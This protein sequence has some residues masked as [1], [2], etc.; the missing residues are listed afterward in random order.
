[1]TDI[2]TGGSPV[3]ETFTS[4]DAR[5]SL[6]RPAYA[7]NIDLW[8]FQD[9]VDHVQR[10][11]NL[12][13]RSLEKQ[14]SMSVVMEA[15]RDIPS[16]NEWS[17]L[18]RRA[19]IT[20]VASQSTGSISYDHTGGANERQVTLVGA[21]F[22]TDVRYYKISIEGLPYKVEEFISNTVLTLSVDSSPQADIAAG[23]V[24]ELYRSIYPMPPDFRR[25]DTLLELNDLGH[26][27]RY[28]QPRELIA[29]ESEFV[30]AFDRP[31][32]FTIRNSD[33]EYGVLVL[34]FGPPPSVS[35]TYDMVYRASPRTIRTFGQDAEYSTGTIS[36]S[37][38]DITGVSTVFSD[39]M[40]GSIMRFTE[41]ATVPTGS[42]GRANDY[43]PYAEQRIIT[44]VSGATTLSIDSVMDGTYAT[45]VYSIG[46]PIDLEGQVM[47]TPFLMLAE[48]KM[49]RI[50]NKKDFRERMQN[51]REQVKEAM[52]ED[53]RGVVLG[54]RL[55]GSTW[56]SRQYDLRTGS[57]GI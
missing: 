21:T 9:A 40:V 31:S 22:P 39:R 42:I 19:Q 50:S 49:A 17:Y 48:A 11:F 20:T 32:A 41:G 2:N 36:V 25:L 26:Q 51:Y 4:G 8:T 47:M 43:A 24:Y 56:Y 10:A 14:R 38:T 1:M 55:R 34:E 12:E 16:V 29:L 27:P 13:D 5:R 37:G 33:D 23:T 35:R 46:D 45:D 28:V 44:S 6:P 54:G 3:S 57:E 18:V 30:V 52:G 15:Y 53:N 7:K